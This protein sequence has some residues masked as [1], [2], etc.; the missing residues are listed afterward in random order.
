[1][2]TSNGGE[3]PNVDC[4]VVRLYTTQGAAP[5]RA[6][7]RIGNRYREIFV[8]CKRL[9]THRAVRRKN[10][11]IVSHEGRCFAEL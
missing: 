9:F 10:R 7:M 2:M 1:M 6:N 3:R 8:L 5:M 11:K 4:A